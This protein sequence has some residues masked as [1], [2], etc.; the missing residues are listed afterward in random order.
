MNLESLREQLQ[1]DLITY[2]SD[3]LPEDEMNFVCQ[4]VV[5]T[6]KESSSSTN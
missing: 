3:T 6:F 1:S 5:D 2:L 4:I